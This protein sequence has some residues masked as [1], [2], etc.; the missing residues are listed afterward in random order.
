MK[1][2]AAA[3]VLGGLVEEERALVMEIRD[4]LNYLRDTRSG[5]PKRRAAAVVRAIDLVGG[6]AVSVDMLAAG[7]GLLCEE[8]GEKDAL[9]RSE[10][11]C[12]PIA[13][14]VGTKTEPGGGCRTG[15]MQ[16][17]SIQLEQMTQEQLAVVNCTAAKVVV[18]AK[19]GSGKTTVLRQYAERNRREPMLYL[20]LNKAVVEE[21]KGRMP[22]NVTCATSH[23]I[24]FR[25]T[26]YRFKDKL[27]QLRARDALSYLEAQGRMIRGSD[28]DRDAFAQCA[29]DVIGSFVAAGG[30]HSEPSMVHAEESYMLPSQTLVEGRFAVRAAKALWRGMCE[31]NGP[32]PMS[33]DGYLKLW[34]LT[35]PSLDRYAT[36]LLDESQDTNPAVMGVMSEQRARTILVGDRDQAIYGFRGAVNAMDAMHGALRLPLATSFRFGKEIAAS[37]NDLLQVF[38]PGSLRVVGAGG[39]TGSS[40]PSQAR[41]FRTNAGLFGAVAQ[42]LEKAARS[43]GAGPRI[44][45]VGGVDGYALD[46]MMDLY[47]VYK[48]RGHEVRDG[49]LRRFAN[50]GLL[51]E[52]SAAVKD[53]E[54]GM[55]LGLVERYGSRLPDLVRMAREAAVTML[56][57]DLVFGSAHK[58]KG[59]EFDVVELADDFPALLQRDGL[60]RE[61]QQVLGREQPDEAIDT[62][63]IN[64][65]Y[66][67]MTRARRELRANEALRDFLAWHRNERVPLGGS[68]LEGRQKDAQAQ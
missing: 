39:H 6:L 37:A 66:V 33:H 47:R 8:L 36:I 4:L 51:R 24:A 10:R 40:K 63:E 35:R 48:G 7:A 67:A 34:A 38:K 56:D 28:G 23:S 18:D 9:N 45:F 25:D 60:P 46:T 42:E 1:A 68:P 29:M 21:A 12:G 30:E 64:L 15:H 11:S 53:R 54:L 2:L 26:G 31:Q 62:Q 50:Y 14:L 5:D 57:A 55:R 32:V 19:A 27:G 22:A 17:R 43:G 65:Y 41:V 13:R 16:S 20:G 44:H 59:L 49:F 58:C 3:Q 52:Y 61:A